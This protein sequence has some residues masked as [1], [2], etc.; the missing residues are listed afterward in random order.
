[1]VPGDSAEHEL[2]IQDEI[3]RT[4]ENVSSLVL[5]TDTF[6]IRNY[7]NREH[8]VLVFPVRGPSINANA[9]LTL[10]SNSRAT[11]MAAAKQLLKTLESLH[12]SGFV[13]GGEFSSIL[14]FFFFFT[15][16]YIQDLNGYNVM[17]GM[18]PLD[19]KDTTTKYKYL[20]RPVKVALA[21]E[22]A[23]ELVLPAHIAEPLITEDIFHGGFGLTTRA[24]IRAM[25]GWE[26]PA[27][28]CAP[29]VTHNVAPS[30]A[31]DIWSYLCIF[32]QLYFGIEMFPAG[33][34]NIVGA[35][36]PLS[37]QWKDILD[38]DESWYDQSMKADIKSYVEYRLNR[39]AADVGSTERGHI[40]SLMST[41]FRY[42]PEE[43]MTATQLLHDPSFKAIM[44][45]YEK[46]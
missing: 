34:V 10:R 8:R 13:H 31:S 17:W 14:F 26:P 35:V 7:T 19:D 32:S 40:L 4:L 3:K 11:R 12:N 25:D 23:A 5:Y 42:L 6:F 29:E 20:G 36:G 24:G 2:R 30:R 38:A 41:G 43:R 1:M 45:I 27:G 21:V 16:G 18:A 33:L 46:Y 37:Q 15:N 9:P 39:V 28:Y 44:E 22:K